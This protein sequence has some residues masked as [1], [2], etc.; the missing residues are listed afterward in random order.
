MKTGII[1]MTALVPT[2]G[3]AR[4]IEFAAGYMELVGMT[5]KEETKLHVIVSQRSFEPSIRAE[6]H[7]F[8][9]WYESIPRTNAN[10]TVHFWDHTDDDAP[11]N[12]ETDDEWK[13]WTTLAVSYSITNKIDYLFGSDSYCVE[14]A[15]RLDASLVPCDPNRDV[16][17]VKGSEVRKNFWAMQDKIIPSYLRNWQTKIVLFGQE[18]VGKTTLAKMLANHFHTPF[19]HEWAR[20][21]LEMVG[22]EITPEKMQTIAH[23]QLILDRDKPDSLVKIQDTD[24][25]STIGYYRIWN[26]AEYDA[27]PYK[28]RMLMEMSI[29]IRSDTLYLIPDPEGVPFYPD[30]LRYGGDR[31]ETDMSFWI[32]ILK[33]FG[34][35][36]QILS[37]SLTDR[38]NTAVETI[39]NFSGVAE[40]QKF[41]RD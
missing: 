20:P 8:R 23:S 12:C 13:Y 11:Q 19:Y 36:Y 16:F 30:Q 28:L 29:Q 10:V 6:A 14:F 5:C 9:E 26:H 41:V 1:F 21:Y 32:D 3:H 33:E 18:S 7:D 4:L 25:L 40:L 2:I 22:A 15:K 35:S 34:Q 37:G 17:P 24:I 31:R 27:L 39:T 38:F